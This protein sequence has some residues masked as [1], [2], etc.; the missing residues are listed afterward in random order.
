MFFSD[1]DKNTIMSV[2]QL[3]GEIILLILKTF[4]FLFESIVRKFV[5]PSEV[6]VKG[7]IVLVTKLLQNFINIH[8]FRSYK[9]FLDNWHW[10][11]YRSRISIEIR[12]GRCNYCWY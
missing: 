1:S 4:Y 6:S 7:E 11:W 8:C 3:I 9:L 12:I 5:T 2:L 10:P